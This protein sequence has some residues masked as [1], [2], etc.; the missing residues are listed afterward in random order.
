[1]DDCSVVRCSCLFARLPSV[2]ASFLSFF[3]KQVGLFICVCLLCFF[4]DHVSTVKNR[5]LVTLP[6]TVM[7]C[8]VFLFKAIDPRNGLDE[9]SALQVEGTVYEWLSINYI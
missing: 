9:G 3:I 8:R 7:H 2:V 6:C 5:N 1:M 4:W